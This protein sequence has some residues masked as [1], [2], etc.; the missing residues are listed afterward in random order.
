MSLPAPT[1]SARPASSRSTQV[2]WAICAVLFAVLVIRIVRKPGNYQWDFKTYYAAAQAFRAGLDPYEPAN[3]NR[4]VAGSGEF[5]FIYPPLVLYAF[6]PFTALSLGAAAKAWLLVQLLA[7]GGLLWLWHRYLVPL[8]RHPLVAPFLLYAFSSA[9]AVD[10]VAGNVSLVEELGLWL[11]FAFLLR[12]R[13][14]PFCLCVG[15]VAQIKLVPALLL[16][17]LWIVP[18]RARWRALGAGVLGTLGALG[19][20]FLLNPAYALRFLRAAAGRD[21]RGP[22]NM[23]SLAL[24]RDLVDEI[25]RP[26]APVPPW[27]AQVFWGVSALALGVVTLRVALRHQAGPGAQDLR[28]RLCLGLLAYGLVLPRF[29]SYSYILLLAPA[30]YLLTTQPLRRVPLVAILILLPPQWIVP[31]YV[32]FVMAYLPF[33]TALLLWYELVRSLASPAVNA[34]PESAGTAGAEVANPASVARG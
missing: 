18:T 17:L 5:P 7:L 22:F 19:I 12:G 13:V 27:V 21:E 10:L 4:F 30:L 26:W 15:L 11:G 34:A 3:L 32:S 6:A 24:W 9:L 8:T 16:G 14:W 2:A 31:P 23:S 20:N 29:M 1:P 28:T 25:G 33:F